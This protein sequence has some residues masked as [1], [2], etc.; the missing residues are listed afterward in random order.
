MPDLTG[1]E[2]DALLKDL[3]IVR[4][5]VESLDRSMISIRQIYFVALSI[6]V[7]GGSSV[8]S[9]L[10]IVEVGLV[11][12]G[13]T[14]VVFIISWA[15]WWMDMH[16]HRYMRSAVN[17]ALNIEKKLGYNKKNR[18]GVTTN[19]EV[20]RNN[21]EEG[22]SIAVILYLM[23]PMICM[24]GMGAFVTYYSVITREVDF[25]YLT[26]LITITALGLI[27][28]RWKRKINSYLTEG[29]PQNRSRNHH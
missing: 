22:K 23:A 24:I 26:S 10:T 18:L 21:S 16:Y 4:R 25:V 7:A 29:L 20:T 2:R 5:T 12:Q 28:V 11:I 9:S 17:T 14:M 3:D 27:L 13:L 8:I 15:L 19:M 1:P 6:I